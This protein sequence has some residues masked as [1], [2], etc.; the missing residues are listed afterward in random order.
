VSVLIGPTTSACS[1]S[2][3]NKKKHFGAHG[4]VSSPRSRSR[5]NRPCTCSAV[6]ATNNGM[7]CRLGTSRP[8]CLGGWAVCC[9]S[10][11]PC[12]TRVASASGAARP[13]GRTATHQATAEPKGSER[14]Y[15]V[16][17]PKYED[18]SF[19]PKYKNL[20]G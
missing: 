18:S 20:E 10:P 15:L 12:T 19:V 17:V 1:V 3:T 6:R 4:A 14:R 11:A 16:V 13:A 9:C 8:P 5:R 2:I 7:R